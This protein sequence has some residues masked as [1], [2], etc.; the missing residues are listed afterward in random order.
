VSGTGPRTARRPCG[1]RLHPRGAGAGCGGIGPGALGA[2]RL[3]VPPAP[4]YRRHSRP[5]G[6]LEE[7][8]GQS[9]A[10]AGTATR[11]GAGPPGLSATGASRF[12][13]I[14][15]TTAPTSDSAAANH[16]AWLKLWVK[17]AFEV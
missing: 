15:A 16:S 3:G 17:V 14:S 9:A 1:A 7:A 8:A 6:G 13:A 4:G 11:A 5:A 10:A 12:G 2:G